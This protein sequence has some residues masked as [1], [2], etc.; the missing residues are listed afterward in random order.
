M[1]EAA[2]AA[3]LIHLVR[4]VIDN[5]VDDVFETAVPCG[6]TQFEVVARRAGAREAIRAERTLSTGLPVQSRRVDQESSVSAAQGGVRFGVYT[7]PMQTQKIT[8]C[9]GSALAGAVGR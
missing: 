3:A 5:S 1:S 9:A 8:A 4:D 6:G 2:S 7:G